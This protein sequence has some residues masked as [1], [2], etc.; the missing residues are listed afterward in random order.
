MVSVDNSVPPN[1]AALSQGG[2]IAPSDTASLSSGGQFVVF[3][4]GASNF[5]GP[6]QQTGTSFSEV[7]L[8]NTCLGQGSNCEQGTTFVAYGPASGPGANGGAA[9]AHS[10]SMGY[11]PGSGDKFPA[12]DSSGEFVAFTSDA[13]EFA[14]ITYIN[15]NQL[16]LRDLNSG[17]TGLVSVDS[18]G[19]PLS[20]GIEANRPGVPFA[21]ST[22]PA[23]LAFA[24][25]T[26]S[27]NVVPGVTN[28]NAY[29]EIYWTNCTGQNSGTCTTSLVSQAST[30]A[31]TVAS[32][33]VEDPAISPDG[34]YVAFDSTA[35]NLVS[36]VTIPTGSDQVYLRDTCP[37]G[38]NGL[39]RDH[40]DFKG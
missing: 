27:P 9:C 22:N 2:S 3:A 15:A 23:S 38:R 26:T 24:Y 35:G 10:P 34:R 21:M 31:T 1:P 18:T 40:F 33:N 36:G 16:Y 14:R 12:I 11:S 20:L 8:R 19:S 32:G 7:F 17:I 39:H 37:S 5:P 25:E 28:P 30:G 29:D 4:A 13:C 6:F